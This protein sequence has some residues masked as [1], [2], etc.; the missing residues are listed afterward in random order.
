MTRGDTDRQTVPQRLADL[1]ES[2]RNR[3]FA[4]LQELMPAVWDSIRLELEDESSSWCL[5]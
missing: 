4:R 3:R 5:R 1:N 2:E